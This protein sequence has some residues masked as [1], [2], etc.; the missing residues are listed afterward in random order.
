MRSGTRIGD[1]I[2]GVDALRVDEEDL[3]KE[4]FVVVGSHDHKG[5]GETGGSHAGFLLMTFP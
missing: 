1:L 4:I 5:T 2:Q 3:V